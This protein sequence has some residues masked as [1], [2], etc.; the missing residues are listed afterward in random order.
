MF[1]Q[2]F[3]AESLFYF[4]FQILFVDIDLLPSHSN[5]NDLVKAIYVWNGSYMGVPKEEKKEK[6]GAATQ[7]NNVENGS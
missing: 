5:D 7:N 4:F 3:S 6:I 2:Q 1:N